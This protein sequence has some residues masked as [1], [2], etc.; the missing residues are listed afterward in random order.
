MGG[1]TAEHGF[2]RWYK[3]GG[4]E[5]RDPTLLKCLNNS[6]KECNGSR[7]DT[8]EDPP[9][10]DYVVPAG[11]TFYITKLQGV[12]LQTAGSAVLVEVGYGDDGV[13]NSAATPTSPKGVWTI[14]ANQVNG[15]LLD[16]DVWIPI[17]AGKYPYIF[18]QGTTWNVTVMGIEV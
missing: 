18:C 11:K 5:T 8:P 2:P 15:L 3:V 7:Y 10:T 6:Q 17:P 4:V 16:L 14:V 1:K 13:A 9:G 12:P